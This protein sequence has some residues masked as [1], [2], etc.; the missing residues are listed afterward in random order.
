MKIEEFLQLSAIIG[1]GSPRAGTT[2]LDMILRLHPEVQMPRNIKEMWFFS[3]KYEKGLKWYA[4]HYIPINSKAKIWGDISTTYLSCSEC[5]QRIKNLLPK[6]KIIINLRN[7]YERIMSMYGYYL[8]SG[9]KDIGLSNVIREQEWFK[10]EMFVTKYIKNY[11]NFFD[12]K[13]IFFMIYDDLILD[14]YELASKIYKFIGVEYNYINEKISK[15]IHC[16]RVPRIRF[17][18]KVAFALQEKLRHKFQLNKIANI[19]K[20]SAI[21]NKL[22]FT[23]NSSK[24]NFNIKDKDV[25]FH[26]LSPHFNQ[27][28]DILEE[29]TG[30]NLQHWKQLPL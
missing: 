29:I 18:A 4:S 8:M 23:E 5:P 12:K 14:P 19:T 27:E 15:K 26:N 17:L 28:T 2:W 16:K 1:V 11:C 25:F 22:L 6:A 10:K 13:N 9:N 3:H 21:I 30:R 24:F 20:Y 7:P